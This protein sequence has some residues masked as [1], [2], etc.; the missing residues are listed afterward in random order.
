MSRH[1]PALTG[2]QYRGPQL[3]Q[4]L[5]GLKPVSPGDPAVFVQG[6]PQSTLLVMAPQT[7]MLDLCQTAKTCT[8]AG[9]GVDGP[10]SSQGN[11]WQTVGSQQA[12]IVC[13]APKVRGQHAVTLLSQAKPCLPDRF[14]YLITSVL[15]QG[16]PVS[17]LQERSC[18]V[19]N[20]CLQ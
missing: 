9:P 20:R 18:L 5:S 11:A 3:Q 8:L 15:K 1:P 14:P 13:A 10:S 19:D 17:N 12:T 6:S 4:Q 7:C 16:C 2:P